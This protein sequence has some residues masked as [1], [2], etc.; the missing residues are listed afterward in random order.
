MD[1]FG[2]ALL[3][4]P[5]VPIAVGFSGGL[6][7]TVLLHVLAASTSARA[8][9]LR[10][11]HVHHGLHPD[12]DAWAIHCEH[13]CTELDVPLQ[14]LH[15]QVDH[16]AGRGPEAAARAA[17]LQAFHATLR[18]G[19]V[20]ALAHH[21]DDQSETILLRLMR[22]AGGDGLTAMRRRSR[23]GTLHLWRPLLELPRDALRDYAISHALRWIED[24]SNSETHFDRNFIRHRVIPLLSERWPQ[25]SRNLARSAGLLAEQSQVLAAASDALLDSLLLS[26]NTL[27]LPGLL[28]QSR[29][30]R[31]RL[32]RAW[33]RRLDFPTPTAMIL[34][35]I[36][37]DLLPARDDG[38]AC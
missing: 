13:I 37:R 14:I 16:A 2:Q 17:R 6:D 22:G 3:P 10:A 4:L 18:D 26:D 15:V 28:A 29:M 36:E 19:E 9:G 12:A 31:A 7:S 24:P 23:L 21:R 30:Q 11:I 33:L 32:L 25:A 1:A 27:S 20:L 5:E 35:A 38:D 8:Q 34:A